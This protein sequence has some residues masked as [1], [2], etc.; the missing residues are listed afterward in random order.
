ML[1]VPRGQGPRG[2]LSDC[3]VSTS[4]DR[5]HTCGV[6]VRCSGDPRSQPVQLRSTV[7][8]F[9]QTSLHHRVS[10]PSFQK[11][12]HHV[13][14]R[15]A[16]D[17]FETKHYVEH[18]K[19]PPCRP[20]PIWP[21]RQDADAGS[22]TKT[23]AHSPCV[24]LAARPPVPRTRDASL[25]VPAPCLR[26]PPSPLFRPHHLARPSQ[27]FHRPQPARP[28]PLAKEFESPTTPP[29]QPPRAWRRLLGCPLGESQCGPPSRRRARCWR[30]ATPPAAAAAATAPRRP[31]SPRPRGPGASGASPPRSARTSATPPPRRTSSRASPSRSSSSSGKFPRAFF[32]PLPQLLPR[33]PFRRVRVAVGLSSRQTRLDPESNFG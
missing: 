27:R 25:V 14:F 23:F 11:S 18:R 1:V 24:V 22:N 7:H 17:S 3:L 10:N 26:A 6:P 4:A 28:R 12:L 16:T 5:G 29:P 19:A 9:N 2:L 21:C 32:L 31:C 20:H 30:G 8:N 13:V 15:D 33:S